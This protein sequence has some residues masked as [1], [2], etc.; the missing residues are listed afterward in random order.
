MVH[1][2]KQIDCPNITTQLCFTINI[3][4]V[5][6][7]DELLD[8]AETKQFGDIYFNILH[9][10]NHMSVQY[11]TPTAKNLVLN[12][13]KTVFWKSD[14]YQK[15]IDNLIRFIDNGP[16]SDGSEFR[17]RMKQ[18]DNYRK[19]NFLDTHYEIAKA[20]GYE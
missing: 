18:T 6:Y 10:P 1:F 15:E 14:F 4:N 13:L 8:W 17:N 20:M 12:K 9:S 3:Q 5:Y 16:G 19:Q 2:T 7:L 11:M